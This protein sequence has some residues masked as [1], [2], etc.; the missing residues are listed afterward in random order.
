MIRFF[1]RYQ[2]SLMGFLAIIAVSMVMT[3]FG[4][5]SLRSGPVERNA[6]QVGDQKVSAND[7]YAYKQ[8]IESRYRQML[9]G[10][11]DTFAKNLNISQQL[12]DELV[13]KKYLVLESRAQGWEP[14]VATA[15]QALWR[16]VSQGA[17]YSPEAYMQLP[18]M[19]QKSNTE[20]NLLEHDSYDQAVND[21]FLSL[22]ES[23]AQPAKVEMQAVFAREHSEYTVEYLDFDPAK[24]TN[25]VP[26]P[27][28]KVLEEMYNNAQT[29]FEIPEQVSYDYIAIR[30][31]D[32]ESKVDVQ[33]LDVADFYTEHESEYKVEAKG[34]T[35]A[36]VKTLDEVRPEIEAAIRKDQAPTYAQAE[37]QRLYDEWTKS[38][39]KLAEFA[40]QQKLALASSNGLI[41]KTSDPQP[42]LHG[43]SEFI[44]ENSGNPNL[45]AE[46]DGVSVLAERHELKEVQYPPFADVRAK[47]LERYQVDK[48]KDIARKAAEDA[49]SKLKQQPTLKLADLAKEFKA[50]VGKGGN[51]S[52]NTPTPGILSSPDV[53]KE[54][55]KIA[56]P[57]T[58]FSQ[59]ANIGKHYL[60]GL[61]TAIKS[62]AKTD[63]EKDQLT[64]M[65]R[66]RRSDAELM[67]TSLVNRLKKENPP[68]I[69]DAILQES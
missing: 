9:K 55:F 37:A 24:F 15:K 59:V 2:R 18:Q 42:E 29:D 60:V 25:D 51:V 10:Q 34:D 64:L 21:S 28:D 33:E 12:I 61:V 32:Y 65:Q 41:S 67:L 5:G 27:E 17:P 38:K 26:V 3:S 43:L 66:E 46:L 44:I 36:R 52:R 20:F 62:P 48:S 16:N 14:P 49:L 68:T 56:K 50:E 19:L 30:P 39:L 8:E 57:Q 54:V 47:L 40:A 58:P 45:L 53:A 13:S 4:I 6:I 23:A 7:F 69:D 22:F 1:K 31:S 35:P 11:Y 63:L